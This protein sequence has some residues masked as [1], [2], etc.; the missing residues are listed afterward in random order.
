MKTKPNGYLKDCTLKQACDWIIEHKK[1]TLPFDTDD[2]L[3]E[4]CT[5]TLYKKHLETAKKRIL[6]AVYNKEIC[7]TGLRINERIDITDIL[8]KYPNSILNVED[9]A[10][11]CYTNPKPLDEHTMWHADH[12]FKDIQI[13]FD[14]LKR[15][16]KKP[17][18]SQTVVQRYKMPNFPD[19]VII[20]E[21][22]QIALELL[23][24]GYITEKHVKIKSKLIEIIKAKIKKRKLETSDRIIDVLATIVRPIKAQKGTVFQY[25]SKK[26]KK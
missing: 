10:I 11:L 25:G 18:I 22:M 24:E 12:I 5:E 16:F 20:S 9:N 15:C 17:L 13:P 8:H 4:D 26:Q 21:Y 23:E 14:K 3:P 6:K 7:I 1:P 19:N 2:S